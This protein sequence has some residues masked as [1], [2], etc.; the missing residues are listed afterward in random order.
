MSFTV[1]LI[2]EKGIEYKYKNYK[3]DK[4]VPAHFYIIS[5]DCGLV[6]WIHDFY[7]IENNRLLLNPQNN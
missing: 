5:N 2:T 7:S 3:I 4:Y 6:S 1:H